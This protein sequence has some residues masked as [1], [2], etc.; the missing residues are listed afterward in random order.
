MAFH[1]HI[2]SGPQRCR[3]LHHFGRQRDRWELPCLLRLDE[4]AQDQLRRGIFLH[5]SPEPG[6]MF[7]QQAAQLLRQGLTAKIRT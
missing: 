5:S 4:E 3:D 6:C 2:H 1:V 7:R